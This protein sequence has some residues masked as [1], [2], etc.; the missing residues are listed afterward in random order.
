MFKHLKSF[1]ANVFILCSLALILETVGSNKSAIKIVNRALAKDPRNRELNLQASR[2]NL[3]GGQVDQAVTHWKKAAGPENIGSFLYWLDKTKK[4]NIVGKETHNNNHKNNN[5]W[6]DLAGVVRKWPVKQPVLNDVGL[7]LLER[8]YVNEALQIFL[9]DLKNSKN[10]SNLLFNTALAYSKL[11]NHTT[12]LEYYIEAQSAGLNSLELLNN[13]GYSLF[14]LN[15]FEEAQTCYELAR[16]LA[17]NDYIVLNNLAACYVKT[18]QLDKAESCFIAAVKNNPG[19]ALLI[20]NLAMCQEIKGKSKEAIRQYEKAYSIERDAGNQ[21]KILKNKIH[22][23]IKHNRY[24]DALDLC[25]LI[26]SKYDDI[27]IWGIQADLLNEL[28]RTSEAAA[29]YRKALGLAG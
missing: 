17:P 10:D 8:G 6:D 18:N 14:C 12:A 28:G 16:G 3:K 21:N 19:D 11:D 7:G 2:L 22:C 25:E 20:N 29:S 1:K 5:P 15:R 9:Q 4:A 23:L 24:E 13:K 27:E 26:L